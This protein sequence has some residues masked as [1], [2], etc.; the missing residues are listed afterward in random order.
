[1]DGIEV[2]GVKTD[3]Q[4]K[5]EYENAVE[6]VNTFIN[7]LDGEKTNNTGLADSCLWEYNPPT[8]VGTDG[9]AKSFNE[10]DSCGYNN[11]ITGYWSHTVKPGGWIE[12]RWY[13][14]TLP[15]SIK[16]GATYDFSG[17]ALSLSYPA[18]ASFTKVDGDSVRWVSSTVKGYSYLRTA[19]QELSASTYLGQVTGVNITTNAEIYK[20][21]NIYRPK[22]SVKHGL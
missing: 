16:I 19:H 1:M 22:V 10:A 3:I 4:E 13:G 14:S 2:Y 5:E 11:P 6:A 17:W 12:G 20:G 21:A 18:S 7:E 8:G 15:D 9:D